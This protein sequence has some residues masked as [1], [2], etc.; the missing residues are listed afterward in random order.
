MKINKKKVALLLLV[1]FLGAAVFLNLWMPRD[2]TY[3]INGQ[4][5]LIPEAYLGPFARA[6]SIW[7]QGEGFDP[8]GPIAIVFLPSSELREKF[9]QY[10]L[11]Y[12]EQGFNTIFS[13]M[14]FTSDKLG[15]FEDDF[16]NFLPA[17]GMG[18]EVHYDIGSG[19]YHF[20]QKE[21]PYDLFVA[22]ANPYQSGF[23]ETGGEIFVRCWVWA[24][25]DPEG[26]SCSYTVK[27]GE[28]FFNFTLSFANL[29]LLHELTDYFFT[30]L[31]SWRVED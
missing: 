3:E 28:T 12:G 26:R 15:T 7:G 9:P 6:R 2:R 19:L 31:D 16:L 27:E 1:T 22:T 4:L 8:E 21:N 13:V 23:S 30:K 10:V 11:K 20:R 5:Y 25:E 14:A 18:V 17:N 29:K 24:N